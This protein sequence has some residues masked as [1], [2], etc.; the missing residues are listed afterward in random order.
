MGRLDGTPLHPALCKRLK[1]PD[2][3]RTRAMQFP[4][5]FK[6]DWQGPEDSQRGVGIAMRFGFGRSS[7]ASCRILVS[8]AWRSG[9]HAA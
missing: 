3:F 6:R 2:L 8:R 9:I 1:C 5:W 7:K 4:H